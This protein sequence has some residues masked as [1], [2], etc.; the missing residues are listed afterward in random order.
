MKKLEIEVSVLP[1]DEQ[2]PSVIGGVT[3]ILL[4]VLLLPLIILIA[5]MALL[6]LLISDLLRKEPAAPKPAEERHAF[7]VENDSVSLQFTELEYANHWEIKDQWCS[8]VNDD[9]RYLYRLHCNPAIESLE[10]SI[11]GAYTQELRNGLLLQLIEYDPANKLLNSQLVF[12]DYA[13]LSVNPIK[14]I[15]PYELYQKP[16]EDSIRGFNRYEEIELT[17]KNGW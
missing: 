9:G 10:N 12:L 4:L 8:E 3:G 16:E 2:K 5:A 1:T 17:I 14:V 13:D 6:Y 7:R 11:A 15:G